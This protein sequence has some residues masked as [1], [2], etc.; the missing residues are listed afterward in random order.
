MTPRA[1]RPLESS[2]EDHLIASC[3]ERGYMCLKF[4]AIS[5]TGVPDRIIFGAGRVVFVELK[6]PGGEPRAR[7]WVVI[8]DMKYL[9]NADVRVIDNKIDID[10]LMAELDKSAVHYVPAPKPERKL[11]K[12]TLI[13]RSASKE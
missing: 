11:T 3:D 5:T 12:N 4:K 1:A 7:Q 2:V 9:G 10:T 8:D 6:R 13:V